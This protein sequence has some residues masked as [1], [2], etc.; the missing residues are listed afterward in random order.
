MALAKTGHR[1]L[2]LVDVDIELSWDADLQAVGESLF[3][4]APMGNPGGHHLELRRTADGY[5]LESAGVAGPGCRTLGEVFQEAE[6]TITEAAL[7]SLRHR[8]LPVHGAVVAHQGVGL[9]IIGAHDAGKTSLGCALARSG[10]SLLSDEIAPVE[11]VDLVVSPFP[12]DLILHAGTCRSLGR[13]QPSPGFKC[14]DGY[15]YLPPSAVSAGP[16]PAAVAVGGLLFPA[17]EPGARPAL[18][19]QNPAHSAR[20]LLEQCFDLEGLGG[21]RAIDC[22]SRLVQLPAAAVAFN[23]AM[24]VLELVWRWWEQ[25]VDS[26]VEVGA[27]G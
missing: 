22:V 25:Q 10:A 9:L 1:L 6:M 11:P 23:S 3:V 5:L 27:V 19:P 4:D 24:D 14:F 21:E 2:R 18:H 20:V 15:R 12:R 13:L 16:P 26:E 7:D 17:R 8:Y